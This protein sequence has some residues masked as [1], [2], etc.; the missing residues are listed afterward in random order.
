MGACISVGAPA[1]SNPVPSVVPPR[2]PEFDEMFLLEQ[3]DKKNEDVCLA[4]LCCHGFYRVFR[5]F[6]I[7]ALVVQT[8]EHS[9][10]LYLYGRYLP[11]MVLER[12]QEGY[13][14]LTDAEGVGRLRLWRLL[15]LLMRC[16]VCFPL[17]STGGLSS[18]CRFH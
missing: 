11:F 1:R 17:R 5:C 3:K 8:K 6:A 7:V 2:P 16:Y 15:V 12:F 10:F 13:P 9:W 14:P 18:C 4:V